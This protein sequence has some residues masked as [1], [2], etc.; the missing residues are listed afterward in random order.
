MFNIKKRIQNRLLRS[1]FNTVTAE[2]ILSIKSGVLYV[3]DKLVP[4]ADA[5]GLIAEA[6]MIQATELWKIL[7]TRDLKWLANRKMYYDS[8]STDDMIAGKMMLYTLGLLEKRVIEV[9]NVKL[10]YK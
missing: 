2:D 7:V 4:E 10:D 5:K 1:L 9:E 3:G 6:R 8:Q